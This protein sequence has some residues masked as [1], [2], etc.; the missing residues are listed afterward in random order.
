MYNQT[1][2]VSEPKGHLKCLA[3]L[4]SARQETAKG[5]MTGLQSGKSL[6]KIHQ[7]QHKRGGKHKILYHI[8]QIKSGLRSHV[9]VISH[10]KSS[11]FITHTLVSCL[12]WLPP[13]R[14]NFNA[15]VN[16]GYHVTLNKKGQGHKWRLQFSRSHPG[17]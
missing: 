16:L 12:Y 14:S 5:G 13:S 8:E 1:I 9:K 17:L 3:T 4:I 11:R 6:G 2:G 15:E 10:K 7:K